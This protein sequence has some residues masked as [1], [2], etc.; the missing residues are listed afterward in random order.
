MKSATAETTA[1]V[2]EIAALTDR[3]E[4]LRLVIRP[5]RGA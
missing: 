4:K 3:A 5:D 2:S 1:A